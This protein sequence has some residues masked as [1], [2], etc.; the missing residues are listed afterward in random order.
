M[1]AVV[2]AIPV[3]VVALISCAPDNDEKRERKL[4][5]GEHTSAM[6]PPTAPPSVPPKTQSARC[7]GVDR[8]DRP[9]TLVLESRWV[10]DEGSVLF[11]VA[12]STGVLKSGARLDSLWSPPSDSDRNVGIIWRWEDHGGQFSKRVGDRFIQIKFT[13]HDV[14]SASVVYLTRPYSERDETGARFLPNGYVSLVGHCRLFY[15]DKLRS[16]ENGPRIPRHP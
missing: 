5:V 14:A 6:G 15:G 11:V 1:R 13:Q 4:D 16:S 12:D 9:Q 3:A 2:L 8:N 7:T 10:P